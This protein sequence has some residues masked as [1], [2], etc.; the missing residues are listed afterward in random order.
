MSE[1]LNRALEGRHP[2]TSQVTRWF[3]YGHLPTGLP[4]DLSANCANLADYM[5]S[6][7]PGDP[8]EL[9]SWLRR[10][11]ARLREAVTR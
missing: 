3:A 5:L 8:P 6:E 4:R 7:L 11:A 1:K 9:R 2:S 10:Q